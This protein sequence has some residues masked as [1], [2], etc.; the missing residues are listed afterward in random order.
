MGASKRCVTPPPERPS[1]FAFV[2]RHAYAPPPSGDDAK[3]KKG[4]DTPAPEPE[5]PVLQGWVAPPAQVTAELAAAE[6]ARSSVVDAVFAE[7]LTARQP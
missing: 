2:W 4:D 7:V 6:Q 3:A 1:H 5:V